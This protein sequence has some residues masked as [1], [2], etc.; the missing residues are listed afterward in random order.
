MEVF[1]NMLDAIMR[2]FDQGVVVFLPLGGGEIPIEAVFTETGEE[3]TPGGAV[4]TISKPRLFIDIRDLKRRPR[5]GDRVR[6]RGEIYR[7]T[8]FLKDGE[9]SGVAEVML[10]AQ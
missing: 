4:V 5:T 7:I 3:V 1:S 6:I 8:N 10:D 2:T 9:G